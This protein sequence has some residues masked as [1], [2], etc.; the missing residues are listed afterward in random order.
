[1]VTTSLH[2]ARCNAAALKTAQ[3]ASSGDTQGYMSGVAG[4]P[5][6]VEVWPQQLLPPGTAELAQR[7]VLNLPHTLLWWW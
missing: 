7:L 5:R 6:G 3:S 1:M 2:M 4:T